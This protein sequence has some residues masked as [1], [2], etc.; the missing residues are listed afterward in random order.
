MVFTQAVK[1]FARFK[2]QAA[3]S[4][5]V[6]V[7]LIIASPARVQMIIPEPIKKEISEVETNGMLT[8]VKFNTRR[9]YSTFTNKRKAF[10][11]IFR[12]TDYNEI[13][14]S[15]KN[16]VSDG[17]M[18]RIYR[19]FPGY[20]YASQEDMEKCDN[21]GSEYNFPSFNFMVKL[22]KPKKKKKIYSI[23]DR[24][25][26]FYDT[27]PNQQRNFG[28]RMA[29]GKVDTKC[30]FSKP[31][32]FNM[33][34]DKYNPCNIENDSNVSHFIMVMIPHIIESYHNDMPYGTHEHYMLLLA[35]TPVDMAENLTVSDLNKMVKFKYDKRKR[36]VSM[37]TWENE[38]IKNYL[39]GYPRAPIPS[40]PHSFNESPEVSDQGSLYDHDQS[41]IPKMGPVTEKK[42][43]TITDKKLIL[44][45]KKDIVGE[46]RV[47]E[48]VPLSHTSRPLFYQGAHLKFKADQEMR[49]KELRNAIVDL[50]DTRMLYIVLK[51]HLADG[52]KSGPSDSMPLID[53][54]D[55][56]EKIGFSNL[57]SSAIIGQVC[58]YG[59]YLELYELDGLTYV[60]IPDLKLNIN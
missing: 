53:V 7:L 11:Y 52:R 5:K 42:T 13:A 20:F 12:C 57:E 16:Y 29:L 56:M 15:L 60:R 59:R 19:E 30:G 58:R 55:Y 41:F 18:E 43:L 47:E 40:R 44:Q 3:R 21:I 23:G 49:E 1:Y 36:A 48:H 6:R 33:L 37:N 25:P 46:G 39:F 14:A 45:K 35:E 31:D 50:P 8:L 17:T 54:L 9:A 22:C 32:G 28:L 34:W 27:I 26:E 24:D 4:G 2:P 51:L 10:V 38:N